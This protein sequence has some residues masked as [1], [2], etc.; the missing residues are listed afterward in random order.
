[1]FRDLVTSTNQHWDLPLILLHIENILFSHMLFQDMCAYLKHL[2]V[3]YHQLFKKLYAHKIIQFVLNPERFQRIVSVLH[4]WGMCYGKESESEYFY[5]Y[6]STIF[7]RIMWHMFGNRQQPVV[8]LT[9]GQE[10][11]VFGYGTMR[12]LP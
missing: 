10:N 2:I 4:S 6:K 1:M 3:Q 9:L 7:K 11:S 8:S 12:V 5:S